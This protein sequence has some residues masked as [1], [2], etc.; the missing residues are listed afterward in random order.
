MNARDFALAFFMVNPHVTGS[1]LMMGIYLTVAVPLMFGA[2]HDDLP[3]TWKV[4]TSKEGR[5]TVAMPGEPT[6]KTQQVKTATGDLTV[7]LLCAEGRHDS[8][9]VVSYS[10]FPPSDLKKGDEDKRLDQ[11]CKGAVESA[12]GK[13][14]GDE[15]P[16]KLA[17][18]YPGREIVIEKK[19]QC[20]AKMR[21]YLVDNRLY[22]VMVLG[23]GPI[24][25]PKEKDAGTFLD[26]FRLSK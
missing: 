26:S 14:R 20:V 21:I 25:A 1:L 19:G 16:I 5:F 3:P 7:T 18:K 6:R 10:D 13:L 22:Q 9:F 2:A 12:R 17:G 4:Q 15:K 24:F 8:F 23:A 11:A